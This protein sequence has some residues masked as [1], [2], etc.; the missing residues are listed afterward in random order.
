MS[1]E[2]AAFSPFSHRRWMDVEFFGDL[3][4]CQHPRAAQ[5]V[6]AGGDPV[7]SPNLTN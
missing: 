5:T 7:G 4:L 1:C 6:V 3:M 2:Q